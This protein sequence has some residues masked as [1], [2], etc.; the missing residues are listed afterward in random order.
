MS[1]KLN[2]YDLRKELN[3]KLTQKI[4]EVEFELET[5]KGSDK[6]T[7]SLREDNGTYFVGSF[8]L[9]PYELEKVSQFFINAAKEVAKLN[10]GA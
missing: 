4:G 9:E 1:V 5:E 3:L 2:P 6:V 7:I 8:E 10:G